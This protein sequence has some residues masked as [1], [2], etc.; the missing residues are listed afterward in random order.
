VDDLMTTGD[1]AKELGVCRRHVTERLTKRPDFPKPAMNATQK[2][3]KWRAKD[4]YKWMRGEKIP[5]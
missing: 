1:I 5:G 2:L 3:R 4:V